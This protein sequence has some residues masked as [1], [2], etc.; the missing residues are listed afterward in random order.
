MSKTIELQV[1]KSRALLEGLRAHVDEL[2]PWG[3]SEADLGAM[4]RDVEALRKVGEECDALRAE[5]SQKVKAM[6]GV[7]RTVKDAYLERK[8]AVK[9]HFPQEQWARY[10]VADK[11]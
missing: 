10:G 3:P 4:E 8:K 11:R 1:E 2:R 6:N 7:L 5:L 9:V